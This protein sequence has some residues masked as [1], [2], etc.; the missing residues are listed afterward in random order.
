MDILTLDH[1]GVAG[2]LI[3]GVFIFLVG[4]RIWYFFLGVMLLFLA[5]SAI[6]TYIGRDY[7]KRQK[8]GQDMRGLR[9]VLA[10]GTVPLT[11]MVFYRI[12]TLYGAGTLAVLFV[13]GFVG[14][15]AAITADKF[16]S[17]IGVLGGMPITLIGFD[18]VKRGTSGAITLL[19]L[20]AS[21]IAS[22]IMAL[23]AFPADYSAAL[24]VGGIAFLLIITFAGFCGGIVDSLFGYYEEKGVGNKYTSNFLC[25]VA[26]SLIAILLFAMIK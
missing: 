6:V 9:N 26:G 21:L 7:K 25:S 4:G 3:M 22:F 18:R 23:I 5:I 8:L 17:E 24:G 16:G 13:L 11:L 12:A 19:G 1:K 2:A 14:S 15:V 10:N 20:A